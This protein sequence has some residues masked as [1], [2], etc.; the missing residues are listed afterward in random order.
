MSIINSGSENKLSWFSNGRRRGPIL[1]LRN[2]LR[3]SSVGTGMQFYKTVAR[4][5]NFEED[6]KHSNFFI[7]SSKL[8]SS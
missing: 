3:S 1:V 5:I 7:Y 2:K 4:E 6:S 8:Y